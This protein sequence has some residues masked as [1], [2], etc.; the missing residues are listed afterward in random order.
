MKKQK[1]SLFVTY[2]SQDQ[3]HLDELLAHLRPFEKEGLCTIAVGEVASGLPWEEGTRSSIE[4]ANIVLLLISPDFV[5]SDYMRHD[6]LK[7]SFERS[8]YGETMIIPVIVRPASWQN[9]PVDRHHTLPKNGMALSAYDNGKRE[10]V[11]TEDVAQPVH[12]L[13]IK[14]TEGSLQLNKPR[15]AGTL[16]RKFSD[17][18]AFNRGIE[19]LVVKGK[20]EEAFDKILEIYNK[21]HDPVY[22]DVVTL[23]ARYKHIEI[24]KNNG[25]VSHDE[26]LRALHQINSSFLRILSAQTLGLAAA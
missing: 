24:S 8:R 10:Q 11:L 26:Y 23:Y 5:A 4:R 15:F 7:Q 21:T 22:Y 13:L 18:E 3:S 6:A 20:T 1:V 16:E 14:M 12:E 2:A 17:H 19:Q 9:L 25:S